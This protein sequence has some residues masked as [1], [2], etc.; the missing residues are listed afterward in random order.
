MGY[1]HLARVQ[2]ERALNAALRSDMLDEQFNALRQSYNHLRR[3]IREITPPRASRK[4]SRR[5]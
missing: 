1:V 4:R 5:A 3:T 2:L